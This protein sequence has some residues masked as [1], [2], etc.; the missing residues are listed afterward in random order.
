MLS[1]ANDVLVNQPSR[2]LRV[3][4]AFDGNMKAW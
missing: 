1:V 2:T 4:M 3:S